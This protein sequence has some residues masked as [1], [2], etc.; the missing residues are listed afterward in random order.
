MRVAVADDALLLRAG[1]EKVLASGGIDVVASV[2]TADELL[3]AAAE[4]EL[5][6]AIIDIRMPPTHTDEGV[7]ALETLRAG[8]SRMGVLLLSMYATPE[9]AM[10]VMESGAGTGYLLKERVSEP[11]TLVRAV[12]T[13]AAGG[14]IVDPEVVEALV[15]RTRADDPLQRLTKRERVVLELMASG[16]SNS[17]ISQELFL[18]IKTVESHVR[19]IMQKLDLEESPD[20]H[21]RVLAVLTLLGKR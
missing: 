13:V 5:D 8:G 2:G 11:L 15:S 20:A 10:R 17:G 19:N 9:Y 16:L 18:G 3:E 14:S 21:R 1:I 7:A 6:A 12:E 4:H